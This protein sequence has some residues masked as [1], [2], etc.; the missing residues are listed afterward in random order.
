MTSRPVQWDEFN[1]RPPH[2]L[3]QSMDAAR[4]FT[5]HKPIRRRLRYLG[6][7]VWQLVITSVDGLPLWQ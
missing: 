1:V 3:S 5:F 6:R 4:R 2:G 7:G